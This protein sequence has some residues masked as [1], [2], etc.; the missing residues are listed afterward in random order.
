[1]TEHCWAVCPKCGSRHV[2]EIVL[3]GTSRLMCTE[4]LQVWYEEGAPG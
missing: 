4:C 3:Y 1:M 2:V